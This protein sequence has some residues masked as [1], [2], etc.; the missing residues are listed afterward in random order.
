MRAATTAIARSRLNRTRKGRRRRIT[1]LSKSI[2]PF[3]RGRLEPANRGLMGIERG[4]TRGR[5]SAGEGSPT[6]GIN[7]PAWRRDQLGDGLDI[8]FFLDGYRVEL[9]ERI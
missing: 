5:P 6:P 7:N 8:D 3:D 2:A 1:T 9:I 4:T